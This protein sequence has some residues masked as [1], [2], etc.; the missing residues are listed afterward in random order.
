ME[1]VMQAQ[2]WRNVSKGA[3]GG[4]DSNT[5]DIEVY[6]ESITSEALEAFLSHSVQICLHHQRHKP[7]TFWTS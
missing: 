5:M 6:S 4:D 3:I 2:W 7:R 1:V